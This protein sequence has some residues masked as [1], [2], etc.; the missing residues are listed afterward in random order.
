MV[1]ACRS[2]NRPFGSATDGAVVD[3]VSP[4]GSC[5]AWVPSTL[6]TCAAE[7]GLIREPSRPEG[8]LSLTTPPE[9][10]PSKS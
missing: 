2:L 9:R 10:S 4:P 6:A 1:V 7:A 3:V 8:E 5:S